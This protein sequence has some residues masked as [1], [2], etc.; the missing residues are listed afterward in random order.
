MWCGS[1]MDMKMDESVDF[2]DDD[3]DMYLC[4]C[5]DDDDDGVF[6]WMEE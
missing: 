1:L 2:G 3:F 4:V 6:G 5:S